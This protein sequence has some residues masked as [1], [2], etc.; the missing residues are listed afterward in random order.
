MTCHGAFESK[1]EL[2]AGATAQCNANISVT[3]M[4]VVHWVVASC[5]E[6]SSWQA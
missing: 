3:D 1:A 5:V 2:S 6:L 4:L